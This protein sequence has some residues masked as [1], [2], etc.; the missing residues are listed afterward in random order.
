M[1]LVLNEEQQMLRDSA[2]GF[3]SESAPVHQMRELRDN[4]GSDNAD[5]NAG[6]SQAVWQ[7]MTDMGWSAILIP[8][9]YGGLEFGHVGMGQIIEQGGRTLTASPLF[10]SAVMGASALI[11]AGSEAQK[12]QILPQ[13]ASGEI[14]LALAI[15]ESMHHAPQA[16]TMSVTSQDSGFV[17]NGEKRFVV[18]GHIA[19]Y[20][21]V[22]ARSS[23]ETGDSHGITLFLVDANQAG[24]K[25]ERT[26][27]VDSRNSALLNFNDV[28][29]EHSAVIG[30][31]HQG[32][33]VLATL[34][35]IGNSHLSAEL[36]GICCETFDRTLAY[37]KER[38]QF[39]LTIG[40]FQSLQ[41]RA[42]H[43]WSEIE[44]C[45]SAVIK[46]LQALDEN[47]DNR[48]LLA[49]GTKAK[50]CEVAELA[51]NE[52]IQMHGG[53]GMTDEFEI[54]FFAKRARSI[55]ALYGD[56]NYHADRFAQLSGY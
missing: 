36:L 39:G 7:Q 40:S 37:L 4:R 52:A 24:I 42:A 50:L 47:A 8:E 48:S 51:T 2:Q 23:G 9:A 43:L 55:Q 3:F 11:L 20:L 13:I 35:D 1:A 46:T 6:Y 32:S 28:R 18:D 31:I 19:D 38:K 22:A 44:L 41:H 15:D 14:K 5:S 10:T 45:K 26:T 34:L 16:I 27:M 49:S 53:V 21:V 56:Y 12:E 25:V 29:V 17:L 30:D 54:G 33:S